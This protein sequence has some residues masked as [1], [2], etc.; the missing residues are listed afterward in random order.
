MKSQHP[1]FDLLLSDEPFFSRIPAPFLT[2]LKLMH[3]EKMNHSEIATQLR[4]PIGTVKSRIFR[5]RGIIRRMRA[6]E[7]ARSETYQEPIHA[8]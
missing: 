6:Q 3:Y 7:D 2:P 4:L 5:A 1:S 8:R